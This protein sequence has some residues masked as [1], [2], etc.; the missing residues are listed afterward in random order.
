MESKGD[1]VFSRAGNQSDCWRGLLEVLALKMSIQ[2]KASLHP[3]TVGRAKSH[4]ISICNTRPHMPTAASTCWHVS[5]SISACR[6]T[7]APSTLR[8]HTCLRR[9]DAP[10]TGPLIGPLRHLLPHSCHPRL[11]LRHNSVSSLARLA[12]L[13]S[14]R[15]A[16]NGINTCPCKGIVM[17]CAWV[18][19][20][21]SERVWLRLRHRVDCPACPIYICVFVCVCACV[22]MHGYCA[23]V[24]VCVCGGVLP[25]QVCESRQVR[26]REWKVKGMR[27]GV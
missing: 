1:R 21:S 10:N 3:C 9:Q 25:G 17:R 4:A 2:T 6:Q 20:G 24:C 12:P 15:T 19:Q 26:E 18:P 22:C 13:V 11:L 7:P 16:I 14:T 5:A 27:L 8:N 23:S